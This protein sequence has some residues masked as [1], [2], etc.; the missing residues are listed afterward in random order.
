MSSM[1]VLTRLRQVL[2][3]NGNS[4][5][6]LELGLRLLDKSGSDPEP[7]RILRLPTKKMV[8]LEDEVSD[9]QR[10]TADDYNHTNHQQQ[11]EQRINSRMSS[12][13]SKLEESL[14]RFGPCYGRDQPSMLD[15]KRKSFEHVL[16]KSLPDNPSK[17][18]EDF[19]LIIRRREQEAKKLYGDKL[20]CSHSEFRRMM[21]HDACFFLQLALLILGGREQL[22]YPLNDV[23]FGTKQNTKDAKRWIESMFFV[24][25]Q[26]P[27]LLLR[28]LTGV[29]FFKDLIENR[30]WEPPPRSSLC[31]VVL[32]ELLISPEQHQDQYQPCD[33]LHSL[34]NLILGPGP[35][36]KKSSI[37]ELDLDIDLQAGDQRSSTAGGS[38]GELDRRRTSDDGGDRR[39]FLSATELN[40]LG[41]SV[42]KLGS[43]GGVRSISFN[44]YY[45]GAV[46]YL[47]AFPVH[48]DDDVEMIFRTLIVYEASQNPEENRGTGEV[49]S[50]IRFMSDLIR[51][52]RDVKLLQKKGIFQVPRNNPD[53][54]DDLP[55]M[56]RRLSNKETPLSHDFRILKRKIRDYSG[57]PW[58][59]IKNIL[60]VVALL[61][62][63]QT[64]F[65]ILSYQQGLRPTAN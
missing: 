26:I 55:E 54:D 63:L 6:D 58:S 53:Y 13:G 21:A 24:G 2:V 50:Y 39:D 20:D 64:V 36:K 60:N 8:H 7:R 31:K 42:M 37:Q 49:S 56:L 1:N 41:I 9:V 59:Q 44:S 32:Y 4:D 40:E 12:T 14:P 34:H 30:N 25:N 22:G 45:F 11:Q 57:P 62:L 38:L 51:T 28:E 47:P 18:R 27:L 19:L 3:T 17:A 5:H 16:K 52:P 61:T 10:A 23:I 33:L 48:I 29:K 46:L 65:T 35:P 43:G 15:T